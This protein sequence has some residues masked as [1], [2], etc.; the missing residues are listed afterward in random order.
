MQMAL[1]VLQKLPQTTHNIIT[2]LLHL[3]G[4]NIAIMNI[5]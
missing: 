1:K 5:G 4:P 2:P 3:V